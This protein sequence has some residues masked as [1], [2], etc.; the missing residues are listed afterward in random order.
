MIVFFF[1]ALP[2]ISHIEGKALVVDSILNH[3][4]LI[5]YF[6]SSALVGEEAALSPTTQHAVSHIAEMF[7]QFN[8]FKSIYFIAFHSFV[9]HIWSWV[10]SGKI[11]YVSY[12]TFR[13]FNK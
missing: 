6:H 13:T 7:F 4:L 1:P 12:K 11:S 9:Q 5:N 8:Y 2:C 10:N 3:Q